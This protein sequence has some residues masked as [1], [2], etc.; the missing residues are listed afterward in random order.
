MDQQDGLVSGSVDVLIAYKKGSVNLQEAVSTFSLL[1][2]LST[3]I[4]ERFV[5]GL[6]RENVHELFSD[7]DAH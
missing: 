3:E 5:T 7:P 2:G 4:A 6:R 1:T